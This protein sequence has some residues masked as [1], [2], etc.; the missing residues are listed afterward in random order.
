M[1]IF[2]ELSRYLC[3]RTEWVNESKDVIRFS[4]HRNSNWLVHL[5][6]TKMIWSELWNMQ[7]KQMVWKQKFGI[8][9]SICCETNSNPNQ[10]YYCNRWDISLFTLEWL[11]SRNCG[12]LIQF[13]SIKSL[14]GDPLN[15]LR[16][17]GILWERRVRK[18]LNSMCTELEVTLQGQPRSVAE[19]EELLNKW[20][21]LSNYQIGI[22]AFA[23]CLNDW[24]NF[25]L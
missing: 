25:N 9:F 24:I 23:C 10:N 2:I 6:L 18:S 15:Y 21:E 1:R 11:G 13:R 8:M 19:K 4:N 5:T 20:D 7:S 17:A 22:W 3:V 12:P 14:Q 16:R